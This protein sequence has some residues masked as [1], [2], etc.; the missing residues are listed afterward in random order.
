MQELPLERPPW[1][2]E[3]QMSDT[4]KVLECLTCVDYNKR[5]HM[6]QITQCSGVD[7]DV[8]KWRDAHRSAG[9]KVVVK[10]DD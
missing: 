4:R 10:A 9:H 7:Q 5:F 1:R 6:H 3:E 8:I 2:G